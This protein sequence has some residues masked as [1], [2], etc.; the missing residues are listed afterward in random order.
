M[1]VFED[2]LEDKP[3]HS[4]R[5]TSYACVRMHAQGNHETRSYVYRAER[6]LSKKFYHYYYYGAFLSEERKKIFIYKNIYKLFSK[7]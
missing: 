4:N 3:T 2:G 7:E 6:K 1:K 5:T